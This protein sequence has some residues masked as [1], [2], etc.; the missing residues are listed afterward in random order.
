MYKSYRFR[1]YPNKKQLEL[2]NKTF[3]SSRYVYN[4]YLDK[5]KN[6]GYVS[7]STN[8][9]DYTSILKYNTPFLQEV[10]S[11]V[12]TKSIFNLD[13]DYKKLFN[14]T[15]GYPKHKSKYN[16]NSYNIPSTYKKYKDKEYCNIELDLT[17]RQIKLPKLKWVKIRGYRNTNNINGKIKNA[18]ISREPNGK[19]YVSIL[20][21]MYD[22]VLIIKPRTIVGIDLGIKK[23]LTLSDGTVYDNNK[24]IDKYTKRIK[25]KQRELSRKEKGSK[26]Y[27]KC[28][29]ELAI[30]YSK[31]ANARKFYTHKI[32]K[33]IT[34][35]YD[36]IT[37]EQL[38]TKEMI[39][40]GK[41]NKLSSK[42]NDATFSEII[43]QFQYKARYKGKVFYQINTY[44]PSSQ[45]CS[46][47]SAQDK[48][49]KD[50]TRRE[51]KCLKCNQEIDRD[52]N[53]SI[54]I[55]F[56]GLKLYMKN[57]AKI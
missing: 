37:C 5:M 24:Y 3:G 21:E 46:R 55:M 2:I 47:C 11:I 1:F 4:Y 13:D 15:G 41:D 43:R 54:N 56:E 19:Y 50:L 9:K 33:D 38:K 44:Y 32:T 45:I 17:N 8:I 53:A 28:K 52:L 27:Y 42:I 39:I 23:L 35:E 16:R 30:L 22:K 18:T 7:A 31:L 48:R 25:R 40:K 10:D 6:K 34:D 29:K 36:I 57:Y 12:L 14:K 51:Y 20:Y 49:Y 26:N